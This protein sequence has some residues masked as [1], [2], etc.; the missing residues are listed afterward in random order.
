MPS[1]LLSPLTASGGYGK[2]DNIMNHKITLV[3]ELTACLLRDDGCHG[4]HV[5]GI[6][7]DK[8]VFAH[9]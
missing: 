3:A 8:V 6:G 4:W 1:G 5:L 2:G 9:L 7:G